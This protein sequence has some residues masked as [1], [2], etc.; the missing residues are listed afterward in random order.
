MKQRQLL[1]IDELDLICRIL[2]GIQL[3]S[4]KY[5]C[6]KYLL[7]SILTYQSYNRAIEWFT[8][9]PDHY[10]N[11]CWQLFRIHIW[12]VIIFRSQVKKNPE[13]FH[14]IPTYDLCKNIIIYQRIRIQFCS[15]MK[16]KKLLNAK[17]KVQNHQNS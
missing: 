17:F 12:Y 10:L 16:M 13:S 2:F 5:F 14:K 8:W 1:S 9:R 3:H 6:F 7:P 4:V 15:K 11:F